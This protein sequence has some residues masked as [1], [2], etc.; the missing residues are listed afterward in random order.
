MKTAQ[1]LLSYCS[2]IH[3][4]EIWSEH[5]ANLQKNIPAVK[6]AVSPDAPMGLGLRIA[7]LASKDLQDEQAWKALTDWLKAEDLYVFTLNGFPFGGFHG[8]VVKDDV[9]T[10]DWTTTERY[11]Y[12]L[13]LA[14]IL[15]KLLPES[16]ASGGISTSPLSYR[17]WWQSP[18]ALQE[19][20]EKGTLALV[21]LVDQLAQIEQNTGKSIHIDIEPEPDGILENHREFVDWYGACLLPLGI[22]H[23]MD[24]GYSA[25]KAEE[26]IRRHIQICFDIC[27][28]GVS[29]DN[30]ATC[31]AELKDKGIQV[32]KIQVSSALRL[33]FSQQ[34]EEKLALL[35]KYQEPVYLHQ[36]K[37]KKADGSFIQY[38]DLD[39]AFAA[40]EPGVFLEWR[41]HY[42]VPLFLESYGLLGSTQKEIRETLAIQKQEAF[43]GQMEIETYTWGVLPEEHQIPIH[44]S[45][46]REIQWVQE[47]LK[48][49]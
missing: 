14:H 45:I 16:Q 11:D 4:G 5:F 29:Y 47:Q 7:D 3:P 36:V 42:H 26:L 43:T 9:H 46:I 40:Y 8:V 15:A 18:E 21:D 44:E 6:A 37:A 25:A 24:K 19:A 12:T 1:G 2:N 20:T 48:A 22:P 27:H 32:G 41:I 38:P 39:Q 31:I 34:A 23:L 49:E 28:F 35:K 33:D 30:P 10:P 13:R 17:F